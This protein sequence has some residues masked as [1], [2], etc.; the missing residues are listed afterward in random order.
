MEIC[1]LTVLLGKMKISLQFSI[2]VFNAYVV[3]ITVIIFLFQ[4]QF[5]HSFVYSFFP[6]VVIIFYISLLPFIYVLFTFTVPRYSYF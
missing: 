6:Y 4:L 2:L 5:L 3:A 1:S